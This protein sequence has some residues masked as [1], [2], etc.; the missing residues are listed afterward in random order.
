MKG[1]RREENFESLAKKMFLS[2]FW[3]VGIFLVLENV[4]L[5][6]YFLMILDSSRIFD[7]FLLLS[8]SHLL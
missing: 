4:Y 2:Y 5:I 7:R 6:Y 1:N 3:I 8:Q